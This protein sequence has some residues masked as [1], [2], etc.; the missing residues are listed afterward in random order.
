MKLPVLPLVLLLAASVA[1]QSRSNPFD[2]PIKRYSTE[3][4][5]AVR[6]NNCADSYA[7]SSS[8]T[9]VTNSGHGAC[10]CTPPGMNDDVYFDIYVAGIRSMQPV[11][12]SSIFNATT[13]RDTVLDFVQKRCDAT[14]TY[15][16]DVRLGNPGS[17]SWVGMCSCNGRDQPL[18]G[19]PLSPY[20]M[21]DGTAITPIARPKVPSSA[22]AGSATASPAATN[23][24]TN[25]SASNAQ[26]S[27]V[28]NDANAKA[29]YSLTMSIFASAAIAGSLLFI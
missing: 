18:S 3:C 5:I 10:C 16:S 1:A 6:N 8:W 21:P 19:F 9:S 29:L 26:T 24:G 14:C 27:P 7:A 11:D 13:P 15:R 12:L 23:A 22:A 28:P 25:N 2:T 20:Y 17:R 4:R